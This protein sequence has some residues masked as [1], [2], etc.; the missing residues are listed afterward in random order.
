MSD[1][2]GASTSDEPTS[3]GVVGAGITGLA[4][5]HYLAERGLDVMTFE[6]GSEPGGIVRSSQIDGRVLEYGPQRARLVP[7]IEALVD[8]L[9]LRDELVVADDD[10]PL[11][12][13]A[14]GR[15]REVPRSLSTFFQTDLLSW[16][17]KCRLLVE[18]LTAPG[19]PDERA[20]SLFARKFGLEAYR[21]V[22][23]P[24]FGGLYGSDPADMPAEH[25]LSR[26]LA[27]EK[28][29][30]SLLRPAV[31]RL[32]RGGETPPPISF[33]SGLQALPEALYEAHRLYVH[34]NTTVSSIETD[35]D[36]YALSAG[37]RTVTVDEVVV[38]STASGAATILESLDGPT[39]A[40]L[41]E[42]NYNSLVLVFLEADAQTEGFGY[43]VRRD[44]AL[45]TRG[46]TFNDSLFDRDGIY[47]VYL[48]GTSDPGA[49]DR[50]EEELATLARQEFQTVM[51]VDAD[52]VEITRL[53]EVIPA[54][55]TS[56]AA[57]E[58]VSLPD[59]ITLAGNYTSRLGFP[60]RFR[61]AKRI[62][63]RLAAES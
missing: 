54:F 50:S 5:T 58:T 30:G 17:G 40:P 12:V 49:V 22:I 23:E 33:D 7:E 10:L 63:D 52:V 13:Y 11:Y 8:E 46:V 43:Q 16:R 1:S 41:R 51:G 6:S 15:L 45:S 62:A 25:S 19:Q 39:V 53:P 20:A 32:I 27:L 47:T 24:L 56:W 18:P 57:L 14:D 59:E 37:G 21:N 44:E 60:G 4:L 38:T 28:R 35:G 48:G 9:D 61:Q 3:V 29:K 31:D 36:G 42:L 2:T 26:L 34:L 55:D